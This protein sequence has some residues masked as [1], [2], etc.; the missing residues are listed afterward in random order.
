VWTTIASLAEGE[1]R[2][3]ENADP[4][5]VNEGRSGGPAARAVA[6]ER[7]ERRDLER[8]GDHLHARYRE[9]IDRHGMHGRAIVADHVFR[10][11]T[12]FDFGWSEGW[13]KNQTGE[14]RER[15][16]VLVIPGRNRSEAVV[17][18][19]HYD[20]A[21]M[22]DVYEP[23]RGG[24]RLRASASGADDN[25]SATTALLLAADVLLPLAREGKLE[26]DVWLVHLTGEE[27]PADCLGA[28][29]LAQE[30]LEHRLALTGET[31]E[32]IDLSRA[33]VVGAFILDMIGHNT[34]RDR[35]V[36]QIAP[37]EGAGSAR[38][39]LFAHQANE[40]W[41]AAARAWN[42]AEARRGRARAARMP[43][44][45]VAPPPF[46]HLPLAGEIRTEWE[47]RSSLYNTDGQIFSDLGI[48]VV[49]FMENYD[50]R[51]SGYHDT[52]DTMKNIDLDYCAALSAIAIETV[53][54]VACAPIV[55]PRR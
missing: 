7:A 23:E 33:R 31:G 19:D 42:H 30:L 26:R 14:A 54:S 20:T 49:L 13:S 25:H 27:F 17:M 29:A 12:D 35:D 41:N 10:W 52:H 37:G 40:R 47:P 9:L 8:L 2:G 45:K 39:A 46:A 1:F 34:E 38:L 16:V 6:L 15:N 22:E 50:I 24:D 21:Y 11:E 53:A 28:R 48:P 55:G 4:V 44:G 18:G 3:Q 32:R 51:R 36:F 43:D 5:R